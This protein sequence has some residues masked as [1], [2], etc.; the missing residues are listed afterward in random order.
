MSVQNNSPN[1]QISQERQALAKRL[2]D[3]FTQSLFS[4]STTASALVKLIEKKPELA[5]HYAHELD[6]M[7]RDACTELRQIVDDLNTHD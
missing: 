4:A 7:L 2:H 1:H 6:E 3:S 5:G